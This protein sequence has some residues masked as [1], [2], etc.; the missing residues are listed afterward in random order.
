MKLLRFLAPL[1]FWASI[2]EAQQVAHPLNSP[3]V[4]YTSGDVVT[5]C[6]VQQTCDTGVLLTGLASLDSPAFIG[7]P[8]APTPPTSDNSPSLA[9]TAFVKNQAY[10]P[11]ASPALTGT[12]SFTEAPTAGWN[13]DCSGNTTSLATSGS[14]TLTTGSGLVLANNTAN[15]DQASYLLGG[16]TV[17]LVA[18][19]KATWVVAISPA[20]GKIG[21]GW[22]G[23]AYEI[24]SNFGSTVTLTTCLIKMS[25]TD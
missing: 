8:T 24:V 25:N 19:T 10:A 13:Q 1:L 9:T 7:I 18:S 15:G 23:T 11:L 16:D 2:A 4:P 3:L 22:T 21:I 6:G 12:P 17:V 14:V 5:F 20:S